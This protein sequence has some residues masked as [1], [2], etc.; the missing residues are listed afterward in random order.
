VAGLRRPAVH[1][2]SK[3]AL[4]APPEAEAVPNWL[5]ANADPHQVLYVGIDWSEQRRTGDRA[6]LE[7]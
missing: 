6:R 5:T 4:L 3:I 1:R 2:N 7:A